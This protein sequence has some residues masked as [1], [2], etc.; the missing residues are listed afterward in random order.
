MKEGDEEKEEENEMEKEE[1][2]EKK[3]EE[4]EEKKK[5]VEDEKK[6]QQQ[7]Q[8][9]QLYAVTPYILQTFYSKINTKVKISTVPKKLLLF[10]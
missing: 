3:K 8:H 1:E 6:K 5:E 7:P 4:E 2:D 9:N 10:L